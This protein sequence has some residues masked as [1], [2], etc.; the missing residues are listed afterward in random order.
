VILGCTEIELLVRQAD[1]PEVSEEAQISDRHATQRNARRAHAVA[2]AVA[3]ARVVLSCA[4]VLCLLLML[5]VLAPHGAATDVTTALLSCAAPP[6][7]GR[8]QVPLYCSAELHIEAVARVAAA[9]DTVEQY[10]RPPRSCRR[11]PAE[12][13]GRGD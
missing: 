12:N 10:Q 5:L 11:P 6:A 2:H 9:V 3:R 13:Q 1:V 7:A 8:V 4:C